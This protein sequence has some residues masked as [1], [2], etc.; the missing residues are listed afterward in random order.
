MIFVENP[1]LISFSDKN[2]SLLASLREV[3]DSFEEVPELPHVWHYSAL[4]SLLEEDDTIPVRMASKW[5]PTVPEGVIA[6]CGKVLRKLIGMDSVPGELRSRLERINVEQYGFLTLVW[7]YNSFGHHTDTGALCMYDI[8]SMM[9]HSCGAS[10][11]WHFGGSDSFCLRARVALRPG[12]EISISYLADE[13]LFKSIPIR[14]EKT[15]GWIFSCACDRC[16]STHSVDYARGFRCPTCVIGSVYVS[17]DDAVSACD[18]CASLMDESTL[19]RYLE[20]E[21]LYAERVSWIDKNDPTDVKAVHKEALNLFSL[22][23]WV[24]YVLE[25]TLVHS[26]T[27]VEEK[28]FLLNRRLVFLNRCFPM[29]NYTTAWLLEELGDLYGSLEK[30]ETAASFFEKGYWT[31]RVLCGSDHPFAE[32]ALVKWDETSNKSI[33]N[34]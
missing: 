30:W 33:S 31:L 6:E 32:T 25:T 14:R 10:G 18:T 22:H 20:L 11:V 13:D 8:T 2:P 1:L 17:A 19:E 29:A 16:S 4:L 21:K 5:T 27:A 24:L 15:L 9:A 23:H 28:I 34:T 26:V 12:D 7:R 3:F